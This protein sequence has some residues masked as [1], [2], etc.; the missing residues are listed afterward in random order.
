[1][2]GADPS[3]DLNV[4]SIRAL[5]DPTLL[6]LAL[7]AVVG[8]LTAGTGPGWQQPCA[9]VL[10]PATGALVATQGLGAVDVALRVFVLGLCVL[11]FWRWT[12]DERRREKAS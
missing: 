8:N 1:M 10:D 7:Q 9:I 2:I 4:S 6:R 11:H 12:E 3:L 5:D